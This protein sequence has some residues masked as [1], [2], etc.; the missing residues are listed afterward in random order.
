MISFRPHFLLAWWFVTKV[1]TFS[2]LSFLLSFCRTLQCFPFNLRKFKS[3]KQ[4]QK[5]GKNKR[6][7]K[8]ELLVKYEGM[9]AWN[10]VMKYLI[11]ING[12]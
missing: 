3:I 11:T 6:V 9:Y 1:P 2:I 4:E 10:I 7:K 8:H 5:R 12:F